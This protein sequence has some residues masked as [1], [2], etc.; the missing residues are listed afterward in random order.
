MAYDVQ[1]VTPSRTKLD[2]IAK[3]L[4]NLSERR[5]HFNIVFKTLLKKISVG[6]CSVWHSKSID[7]QCIAD[8]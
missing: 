8:N 7:I 5:C 6:S 4:Q 3:S 1:Y 2:T